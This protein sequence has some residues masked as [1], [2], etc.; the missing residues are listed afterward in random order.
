MTKNSTI[1]VMLPALTERLIVPRVMVA[2]PESPTTGFRYWV[3]SDGLI[4]IFAR[5][6][7]KMIS[8]ELPVST[9]ILAVSI[10]WIVSSITRR[11]FRGLTGSA[12]ALS[13]K[14]MTSL[15]V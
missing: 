12:V 10:F 4:S 13:L 2:S 6:F 5:V 7:L 8:A 9:N 15:P 1:F 14:E 11:S 3:I